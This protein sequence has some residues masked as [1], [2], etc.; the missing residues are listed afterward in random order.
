M[1]Y[2]DLVVIFVILQLQTLLQPLLIPYRSSPRVKVHK[3][4]FRNLLFPKSILELLFLSSTALRFVPSRRR[5]ST[6]TA[7]DAADQRARGESKRSNPVHSLAPEFPGS[8]QG[9]PTAAY[10][11]RS[12]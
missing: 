11:L 2:L 9:E 12:G 7:R 8:R 1:S 5:L 6:A 4:V 10:A 3:R